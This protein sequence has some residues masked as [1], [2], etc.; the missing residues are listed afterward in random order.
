MEKF[1]KIYMLDFEV[2]G[3]ASELLLSLKMCPL[4]LLS[5]T[6]HTKNVDSMGVE[7]TARD[8]HRSTHGFQQAVESKVISKR[9][10]KKGTILNFPWQ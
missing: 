4:S 5:I 9:S 2:L 3:G 6:A 1:Q 10:L 8:V 7:P